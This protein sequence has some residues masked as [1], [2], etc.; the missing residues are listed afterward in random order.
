MWLSSYLAVH[1][2]HLIMIGTGGW[3]VGTS[4]SGETEAVGT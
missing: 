3:S 4:S 1:E 2:A